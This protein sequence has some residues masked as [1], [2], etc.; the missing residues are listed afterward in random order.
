VEEN[1]DMSYQ[2]FLKE[3]RVKDGHQGFVLIPEGDNKAHVEGSITFASNA[4]CVKYHSTSHADNNRQCVLDSSASGLH[5]LGFHRLR[6]MV[7]SKVNSQTIIPNPMGSLQDLF[8]NNLN[9]AEAKKD[10]FCIFG[11]KTAQ[12]MKTFV[13]TQ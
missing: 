1:T 4:P 3:I 12:G 9:K 2:N 11:S 5:Y 10:S 13:I 8:E 6:V 7:A